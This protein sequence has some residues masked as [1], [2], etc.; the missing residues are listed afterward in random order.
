MKHK[1]IIAALLAFSSIV[2]CS[3]AKRSG[4]VLPVT[5]V[6][7]AGPRPV[8]NYSI[9]GREASSM[10]HSNASMYIQLSTDNAE[11]FGVRDMVE[12]GYFGITEPG[13]TSMSYRGVI[14]EIVM[15]G[16]T[17][18]DVTVSV[19]NKY[20]ADA[21]GFGM[22]GLPWITENRIVL[23]Y[24]DRTV[25]IQPDGKQVDS[26]VKKLK[27]DG[28]VEVPMTN[29]DGMYYVE[30]AINGVTGRFSVNT[31][32]RLSV[33]SLFAERAGIA[34]G[35]V[36]G[37]F[38]GPGGKTGYIYEIND[39]LDI[40]IGCVRIRT[41]GY[42]EDKYAYSGSTRPEKPEDNIGGALSGD[43]LIENNA[44]VDFGNC[45]LYLPGPQSAK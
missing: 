31:V 21:K 39:G 38:G 9:N 23:N 6:D 2:S 41:A 45:K 35:E 33:D 18:S 12:T 10:I 40:A 43:F 7:I 13:K 25:T 27:K 36:A 26:I 17:Y 29:E 22:L 32:S 5:Y 3:N 28:Y 37:T 42:I 34:R 19:F 16:L 8:I 44:V 20:P 15:G 14:D 11:Y 30:A 4:I 1:T 24:G